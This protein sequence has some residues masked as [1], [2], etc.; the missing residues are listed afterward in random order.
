MVFLRRA[1]TKKME[2]LKRMK[3]EYVTGVWNVNTVL[4]GGLWN[5]P[6]LEGKLPPQT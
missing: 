1:R 2:A 6:V 4:F 5:E 3:Q